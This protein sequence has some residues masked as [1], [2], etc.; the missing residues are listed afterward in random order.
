MPL[1]LVFQRQ[2]ALIGYDLEHDNAAL[3]ISLYWQAL[4]YPE[5]SFKVFIHVMDENNAIASQQDFIPCD[6]QN[7][8]SSWKTGEYITDDVHIDLAGL[9]AGEYQIKVGM[10]NP[11]DG[12]RLQTSPPWPG[13]A[14]PLAA[15]EH[16]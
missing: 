13:N 2:I 10:Y 16:N 15:F 7:P 11:N 9:P 4:D 14:V 8:T 12:E 6:W 3:E 5:E 1:D